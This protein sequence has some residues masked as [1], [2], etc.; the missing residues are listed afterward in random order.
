MR[1]RGSVEFSR[2]AGGVVAKAQRFGVSKSTISNWG[3]GDSLPPD[4]QREKIFEAG[5][6]DPAAWDEP[7]APPAAEFQAPDDSP[8]EA[9]TQ[10]SVAALAAVQQRLLAQEQARLTLPGAFGDMTPDERVRMLGQLSDGI[11][12]L[13]G[14]TGV[15]LTHR[16]IL[17][18]PLWQELSDVITVAL[19]EYPDAMAKVAAAIEALKAK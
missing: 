4:H 9:A 5:G 19:E 18:S 8:L 6:P 14:F 15:K 10:D 2:M 1:S 16:Q 7:F 11:A 3:R 13:S 17:A 12:K